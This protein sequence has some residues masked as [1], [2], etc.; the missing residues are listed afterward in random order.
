MTLEER[1][2]NAIHNG[3]VVKCSKEE[4]GE[5]R[6]M[7]HNVASKYIDNGEVLRASIALNEIKRLDKKFGEVKK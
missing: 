1:L 5:V 7:L 4:Y 6:K 2:Q 3:D